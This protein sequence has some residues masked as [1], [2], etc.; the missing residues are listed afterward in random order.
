MNKI[1]GE[2]VLSIWMFLIFGLIALVVF[3]NVSMFYGQEV[4]IR[5]TQSEVLVL[6]LEDC[7]SSFDGEGFDIGECNVRELDEDFY[8]N[9]SVYREG[10]FMRDFYSGNPS[11][12]VECRLPGKNFARCSSGSVL[13]NDFE[14]E[15][16]AGS[17]FRG[18]KF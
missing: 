10:V 5:E 18:R 2:K 15:I 16:Y 13:I 8:F 17:N 14:V 12:E 7:F 1:G 9:V 11:F 6:R 3:V 4:D